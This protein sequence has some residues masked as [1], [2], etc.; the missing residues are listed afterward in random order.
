MVTADKGAG[1][2]VSSVPDECPEGIQDLGRR[3]TLEDPA[4]RPSASQVLEALEALG[5]VWRPPQS[6]T[7]HALSS[8]PA[9]HA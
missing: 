3:C 6:Q 9:Q 1:P 2:S 4:A 7:E 8:D 5:R